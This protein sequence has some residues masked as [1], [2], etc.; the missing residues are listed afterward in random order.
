M[1]NAL[2]PSKVES[3]TKKA[4]PFFAPPVAQPTF[5]GEKIDANKTSKAE[6]T[7]LFG[8]NKMIFSAP[9]ADH[10]VFGKPKDI[11]L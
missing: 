1:D 6:A 7:P 11:E 10:P 4:M 3:E 9:T 8:Q 2:Q 5:A